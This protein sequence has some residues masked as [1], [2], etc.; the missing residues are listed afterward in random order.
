MTLAL[1]LAAQGCS[2][3]VMMGETWCTINA[4]TQLK[5]Y[6]AIKGSHRNDLRFS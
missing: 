3:E 2:W 4:L 5:L 1:E 6:T